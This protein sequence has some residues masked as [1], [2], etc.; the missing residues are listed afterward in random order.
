MS[1]PPA[2]KPKRHQWFDHVLTEKGH[3]TLHTYVLAR[4]I[5]GQSWREIAAALGVVT[6]ES[7]TETAIWAW[8]K[9]DPK[10]EKASV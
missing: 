6:G 10:I 9:D 1:P 3:G 7:V 2:Y 8:F 5:E 4:R